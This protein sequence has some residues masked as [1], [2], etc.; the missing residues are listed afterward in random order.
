VRLIFPD[1]PLS[2]AGIV[3][4]RLA[5]GDVGWITAACRDPELSRYIPALPYPYSESDAR[6][7]TKRAAQGWSEGTGAAFV[8]A[9][10]A[11]GDGLGM[12]ELHIT[13][14]DPGLAEIGYWLRREARGHGAATTA[15]RLA[16][17]W[18]F[19]ELGI[20]RL[21][22][23]TLPENVPSQRVADRAG[24]TREGLLRA[25][26]TTADR[27]RDAV[28]YSLLPDDLSRPLR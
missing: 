11:D 10:A 4:R 5:G 7:F 6:A 3:L 17:N 19:T 25:W 1:P 26:I 9:R 23:T 21:N 14:A 22:L 27:R 28:M 16:A 12:I 2:A 15:V 8:I 24:F 18:A 20:E 13:D